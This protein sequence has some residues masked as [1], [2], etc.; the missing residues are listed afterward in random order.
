MVKTF[1][2]KRTQRVTVHRDVLNIEQN[3]TTDDNGDELKYLI[4][5]PKAALID[6]EQISLVAQIK[7]PNDEKVIQE[8]VYNE[9]GDWQIDVPQ[10]ADPGVFEVLVKVTGVSAN[11]LPFE[12][13]QGPYEVDY[14]PVGVV[15]EQA[16]NLD[17]MAEAFVEENLEVPP[18]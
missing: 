10:F 18:H 1:Q 14:T 7:A 13:I 9:A 8:A 3:F 17:A 2:R 5:K 6:P 16:P 11:E 4:V 12:L 15:E